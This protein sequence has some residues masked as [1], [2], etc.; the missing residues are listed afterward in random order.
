MLPI[1]T[2]LAKGNWFFDDLYAYFSSSRMLNRVQ[3]GDAWPNFNNF[4]TVKTLIITMG[5]LKRI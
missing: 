4:D 5:S 1:I 2:A 3:I